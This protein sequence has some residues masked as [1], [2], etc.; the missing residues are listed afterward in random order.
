[1]SPIMLPMMV[2]ESPLAKVVCTAKRRSTWSCGLYWL[3]TGV[4][5]GDICA[6]WRIAAQMFPCNLQGF[7]NTWVKFTSQNWHLSLTRLVKLILLGLSDCFSQGFLS[8]FWV[9]FGS[10]HFPCETQCIWIACS[11]LR[12]KVAT[13]GLTRTMFL[14]KHNAFESRVPLYEVKLLL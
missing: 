9:A 5:A 10:E 1:M 4:P 6:I 14:V 11:V 2:P 13:L 12:S 7:W 3:A 8:T